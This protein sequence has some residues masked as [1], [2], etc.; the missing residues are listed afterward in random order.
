MEGTPRCG[1]GHEKN[2]NCGAR[3]LASGWRSAPPLPIF[4]KKK[5]RCCTI[6]GALLREHVRR[7]SETE[8]KERW[9]F[10]MLVVRLGNK[11][12]PPT[13]PT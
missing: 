3:T 1:V 7:F 6:S 8:L 4:G 13:Y 10:G 9:R 2:S 12:A 11:H 5:F